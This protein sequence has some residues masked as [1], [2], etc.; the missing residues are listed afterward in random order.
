MPT[1][2]IDGRRVSVNDD[3]TILDAVR[4]AGVEI[5][6]LCHFDGLEP[7]GGCRLCVVDMSQANWDDDWF[8]VVTACN[9]PVKEGMTV[10]TD[11]ERIIETRR[12]VLD[13]LLARCPDTPLVQQWAREYGIE[14]TSYT[15]NPEPDDCILCGLCT[16]VCT[17][18][19]G[20]DAISLMNRG[21]KREVSPPFAEIS[22]ACIGCGGCAYVCPTGTIKI[23][24]EYLKLGDKVFGKLNEF[25]VKDTGET[26][27]EV[28]K[29]VCKE[30][31]A[32]HVAATL[33]EVADIINEALTNYLGWNVHS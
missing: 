24:G 25:R 31:F 30:G 26:I 4:A 28:L 13:L 12:V 8:K 16:R 6:T 23:D 15:P 22:D 5:P 14:R 32:H 3:A 27:Q 11:S 33:N 20:V 21:I 2:T 19:A 29:I 9:H 10:I 1:L 17:E 7:W 18:I